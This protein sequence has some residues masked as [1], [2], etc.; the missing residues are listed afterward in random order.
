MTCPLCQKRQAKRVCPAL[1]K[2]I[3]TVCCATNRLVEIR[4]PSDCAHLSAGTLF[5]S[6]AVKRQRESDLRT[7]MAGV[8]RMSE[9][10]VELFFMIQSYA[11]R[12]APDGAP[13]TIDAEVADAA[14]V[15]AATFDT[16]SR[17]IIFEQAAATRNG[18]RLVAEL[19]EV[20]LAAGKGGG[21]RFEREVADVLRAIANAAA[22]AEGA[23]PTRYVDLVGRVLRDVPSPQPGLPSSGLILPT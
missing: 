10:Q 6:A 21:S 7:L 8:G 2:D 1:G 5:P 17:G 13:R 9:G 3:C 4:C 22:P 23:S 14:S 20:L 18:Q 12:P 19:K 16:A 15:L 11:V